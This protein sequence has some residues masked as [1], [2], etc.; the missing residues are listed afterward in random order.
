MYV[1]IAG[2]KYYKDLART[3]VLKV[4]A[5]RVQ[6]LVAEIAESLLPGATV[7]LVG[8]FRRQVVFVPQWSWLL[9]YAFYDLHSF[10]QMWADVNRLFDE[11]LNF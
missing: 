1:S 9:L 6:R 11:K 2:L 7:E 10:D 4:E 8:G 5:D 3:P